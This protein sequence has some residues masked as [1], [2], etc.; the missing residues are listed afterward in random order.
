MCYNECMI[1]LKDAL[2]STSKKGDAI[3]KSYY[4]G[5]T[6]FSYDERKLFNF[7]NLKNQYLSDGTFVIDELHIID[8]STKTDKLLAFKV[9]SKVFSALCVFHL[10]DEFKQNGFNN[11][12]KALLALKDYPLNNDEEKHHKISAIMEAI[13]QSH[14]LYITVDFNDASN[15]ENKDYI[16]EKLQVINEEINYIFILDKKIEENVS[17]EE[18]VQES[19]QQDIEDI[20][21]GTR[22]NIPVIQDLQV[23]QETFSFEKEFESFYSIDTGKD[24]NTKE[25]EKVTL[26]KNINAC[27]N[28][29]FIKIFKFT[30]LLIKNINLYYLFTFVFSFFIGLG[31]FSA[32]YLLRTDFSSVGIVLIVLFALF[33]LVNT[34]IYGS[35]YAGV[36]KH[37]DAPY[38]KVLYVL[39]FLLSTVLG[40]GLS[41]LAI[42]LMDSLKTFIDLQ[43]F[44]FDDYILAIISLPIVAFICCISPLVS[45]GYIIWHKFKIKHFQ[46]NTKDN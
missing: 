22:T 9:N 14:P 4:K 40:F 13:I 17:N 23:N 19:I 30:W 32:P 28:N 41:Y 43:A 7:L 11:F 37:L 29:F 8:D 12:K 34:Y 24:K 5:I 26:K 21:F 36:K 16:L 6:T 1:E 45:K 25:N 27:N 10:T 46:K 31:A 15:E 3:T 33:I 39:T 18:S 42:M 20:A 38:K 35:T 44:V 2:I